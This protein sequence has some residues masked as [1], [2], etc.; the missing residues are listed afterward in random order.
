MTSATETAA[1]P[2]RRVAYG[3][4]AD[5]ATVS[6]TFLPCAE[7]SWTR[8]IE[9]A[10]DAPLTRDRRSLLEVRRAGLGERLECER[11]ADHDHQIG[12]RERLLHVGRDARKLGEP[13]GRRLRL[14]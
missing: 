3:S 4:V 9:P 12:T 7:T 1:G 11:R 6:A 10:P 14:G 13:L 8:W 5:S 2:V